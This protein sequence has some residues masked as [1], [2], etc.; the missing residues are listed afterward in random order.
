M[1]D[2]IAE[3]QDVAKEISDAISNPVAFGTLY[4]MQPNVIWFYLLVPMNFMTASDSIWFSRISGQ[5]Y[6]EDELEQELEALEQE[7]LDKDLLGVG[8]STNELPEVPIGDLKEPAATPKE[9]EK[10][11]GKWTAECSNE[12]QFSKNNKF[13]FVSIH[14]FCCL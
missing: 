2:D 7:E 6:D 10:K 9:K 4:Y 3:Q 13:Q 14:F 12:I 1:M 5:D 8:T 11:K